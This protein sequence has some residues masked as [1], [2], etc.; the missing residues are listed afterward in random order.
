M[1]DLSV[2]MLRPVPATR[3]AQETAMPSVPPA[4]T[5]DSAAPPGPHAPETDA[6]GPAT[7][8]AE[9]ARGG[10]EAVGSATETERPRTPV[11]DESLAGPPPAFETSLLDLTHDI[12]TLIRDIR[13]ARQAA[14]E[15]YGLLGAAAEPRSSAA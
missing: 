14:L 12:D 6:A 2:Q 5:R 9:T 3:P 13:S 15:G 4:A 11:I 1:S 7:L 10:A 8:R